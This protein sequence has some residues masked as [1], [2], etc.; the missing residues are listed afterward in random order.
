MSTLRIVKGDWI[1]FEGA[2][3]ARLMPNFSVSLI[4]RL[5][6]TFDAI[7]EDAGYIAQ[8]EDRIAELEQLKQRLKG[9]AR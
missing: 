2:R 3:I 8:L 4:A 7:D 9:I 6:E 5:T 1:E